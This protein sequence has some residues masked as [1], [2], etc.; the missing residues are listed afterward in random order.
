LWCD[1]LGAI[2]LIAN[3]DYPVFHA[4]IN[5]IEIDIY[6]VH[7]RVASGA[8]QVNIISSDDQLAD[9]FIKLATRQMLDHFRTNLNLT[10]NSSL[11]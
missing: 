10:C 5:H 7:E 6:F 4:Q 8:L 1:N 3:P 2:Y 9:V 11:D